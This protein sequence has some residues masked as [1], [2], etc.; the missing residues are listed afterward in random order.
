MIWFGLASAVAPFGGRTTFALGLA[1]GLLC[2][3]AVQRRSPALA[4]AAGL[5]TALASPVAGLFAAIA[6]AGVLAARSPL[7]RLGRAEL[8]AAPALAG[9]IGA[10]GGLAAL[11][12][13][14]PTDGFQP[15]AFS[16]YIWIPLAVAALLALSRGEDSVLR[17]AALIY[18]AVA[19]VALLHDSP[20]GGNTVRLGLTVAG[21]LFAIL[22]LPR[23]PLLLA[24]L[25]APLLWWQWTATVRDVAAAEGDP[26]TERAY[27]APLLA[28]LGER[29]G[30]VPIRVEVPP[31]R[32][33]W[34]AAYVAPE[35][36]LARGWLRQ[37]EADD[38]ELF[39]SDRLDGPAYAEWLAAHG[40][41]WVALSDAEPDYLAERE[42]E[43]IEAGE[44]PGLREVWEGGGWRLFAV[45]SRTDGGTFAGGDLD[46]N[47]ARSPL[48]NGNAKLIEVASDR[49]VVRVRGEA[50]VAFSADAL[51][52]D[53]ADAC[54]LHPDP[55]LGEHWARV[56]S[57]DSDLFFPADVELTPGP[58][59]GLPLISAA[60]CDPEQLP[61][62][63]D[64]RGAVAVQD[65]AHPDRLGA[66]DVLAQVVDEDAVRG[67]H[68]EALGAELVDLGLWLVQADIAGDHGRVEEVQRRPVV[69]AG[70]PGVGDQSGRHA[71]VLDPAHD[72]DHRLVGAEAGEEALDQVAGIDPEQGA[73]A[74]L[75]L[76][77]GEL[78]LLQRP[79]QGQALSVG[80]EDLLDSACFD[81][82]LLAE[83]GERGPDV[84][85]QHAAEIDEQRGW[86][87]FAHGL[88]VTSRGRCSV[89]R[90][91]K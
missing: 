16:A 52:P 49:L 67:R 53:E 28:E 55:E 88:T 12:L 50:S 90:R 11:G 89:G 9:G 31:T 20:L 78:A 23:R 19:T 82:L 13:G 58:R 30:D 86:S 35:F 48:V 14:F 29:A 81:P 10:A 75:E 5:L 39:D 26:S 85:R 62:R 76:G 21:P 6:C 66:G 33:R 87:C 69:D 42:V 27:Y 8:P 51:A 83:G 74:S 32:N 61:Q 57:R 37:L 40:V 41:S 60:R 2:L 64:G 45:P 54:V 63:G 47:K 24:L 70:A 22:L 46:E 91:V 36:P 79:E 25:A 59:R 43:L 56:A 84:G 17:W 1:L 71:R 73:E 4:G 18:L 44:V 38:I 68:A 15:F 72:L 77:V 7:E 34:E 3:W 80:A 65:A